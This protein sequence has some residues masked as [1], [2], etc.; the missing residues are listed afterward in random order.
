MIHLE[1]LWY[2]GGEP[3]TNPEGYRSKSAAMNA[4]D[5]TTPTLFIHG[6]RDRVNTP[7][8][9][10]IFFTY[11]KDIGNVDTQYLF[12]KRE[13]HGIREPR[14]QRTR[15]YEEIKWIQKYTLGEDWEPWKRPSEA[16]SNDKQEETD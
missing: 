14:N 3:W 11:L 8:Q 6:E 2:I 10:L 15:D 12:L 4:E 9:S 13:V 16:D 7:Q 1:E 5:V